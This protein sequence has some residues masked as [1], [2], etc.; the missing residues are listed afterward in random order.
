MDIKSAVLMWS[1][2]SFSLAACEPPP[3][4]N[5][6][7]DSEQSSPSQAR[8]VEGQVAYGRGDYATAYKIWLP[9]AEQGHVNAQGTLGFLYDMGRGVKQDFGEAVKWYREAAEQG[10]AEA[11]YNL[12][13]NYRNGQ[14]VPQD[15]T[16]AIKWLR[17]A[18]EQGYPEAYN[19]LGIMYVFGLGVPK[20]Y[21]Q[22]HTWFSLGAT[23]DGDD[24]SE[25]RDIAAKK[26]TPTEI[27]EAE[28]LA[29][30]WMEKHGK[31]K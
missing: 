16:E 13:N 2:L 24:A 21:I 5:H 19:N 15:Y 28:R 31:G 12:G 10:N 4:A 11:Q 1:V 27:A 9:L 18:A 25:N 6:V 30:E 8:F 17:K 22:A 3:D 14:G 7:D 26:M 23:K 20:D 29:Q